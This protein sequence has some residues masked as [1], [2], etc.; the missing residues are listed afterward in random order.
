MNT[1][2]SPKVPAI[3]YLY[4]VAAAVLWGTSGSVAKFLFNSGVTSFQMV[5]LRITVAAAVLFLWLVTCHRALLRIERRDIFYFVILGSGAMAIVQFTYLLAIS[6]IQ[7]AAAILLQYLAPGLIAIYSAVFARQK[8]TRLMIFAVS[9][10]T[11]GCYLVV[12]A[13]HLDVLNMNKVGILSGI[14]S[15]VTFAWYSLQGE[16]G[17]RRYAPWT[18][19]FYAMA[20]AALS[21]NIFYPPLAAFRRAYSPQEWGWI[22]FVAIAGTTLPFGFYLKGISL[23]RSTRA[24]I[25]ATLEPITAGAVSYVFLNEVMEPLQMT[26]GALVLGA[27]ILLQLRREHDDQTP[28]VL[29]ARLQNQQ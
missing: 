10:A 11:L 16:Y 26:G 2:P 3:G 8:L 20:F 17:M 7:V 19:L 15:A 21:W 29:R 6:K 9:L 24:S 13:Y 5:Q 14:L 27:I 18:V 23:V 4:V 25:T 12:G 28:D 1:T 22:L